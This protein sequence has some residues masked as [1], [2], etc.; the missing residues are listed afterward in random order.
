MRHADQLPVGEHGARA[1]AAVVQDHVHAGG[2]QLG[3]EALGGFAHGVAAVHADRADH[4]GEGRDGVRPD[5]AALVVV[6]F[7]GSG[8]QAR[9]ADTVAAHL[10]ELGLAV[11]VEERGVHGAAVLGAQ[12]EHVADLDAALDGQ[13]ALAVGRRVAGQHVAQVGHQ[14]RLGQVAAPVDAGEV[15][16]FLVGA[17]H[18][19]GHHGHLAVGDDGHGLLQADRAQIARLGA[20]VLDDLRHGGEAEA[21]VQTR[22]L[23]R[24][25]L[26]QVVVAT[27]QQQPDAGL[28]DLALRVQ[29]VGGEHQGLDG[30]HQRQAQQLR[31]GGA[32]ALA[33]RGRAG[34]RL[35]GRRARAGGRQRL[36]FLHV[37]GV[38]AA[39]AVDDGVLAGVGDDL[40]F[41]AQITAD[42][43]GIGRHG[44][45]AQ[46]EAVE[47]GAVGLRHDLIAVLGA[48]F[49]AVEAVG[50]LHDEFA[51]AHQAEARAALVAEL[52][53]DL[54][55]VLRQLLVAAQVL[56][57]DVGDHFLA[58]GLDHEITLVPVRDAQQLGPH[59]LE[60][61]ALLPEFA[62]LH[63][64][65]GA[66]HGAG[67]VH[68]LA[69]DRLH[70]ADHPQAHGHVGVDAGPELLDHAGAR[71]ELVAH[72]LGVGGR[73]LE[74]GNVELGGFHEGAGG[75]AA[76]AGRLCM[77]ALVGL[78]VWPT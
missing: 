9:D 35:A 24:L 31:H 71:H 7:D 12:V 55:E 49:V 2:Q 3:V 17:A 44:A 26:V 76:A 29:F 37:G 60:A 66:F 64:R 36:G 61:A 20:E 75:K 78:G 45:V 77:Q 47:D 16:V 33:G 39:G 46:A 18:P 34:H 13:L 52:G 25:D 14:V 8:R 51:P 32:G 50:I 74:R 43:A 53:L 21:H 27:Q 63:H 28:G 5:D 59:L 38:V 4:H 56:T 6:L 10:E 1:L 11:L 54:V 30:A 62:R 58:G 22:H 48:G 69:H 73:F 23:A 70:L 65:H 42:G 19:V 57:G 68:L 72:D 40:E 67:A 15:H 41:L